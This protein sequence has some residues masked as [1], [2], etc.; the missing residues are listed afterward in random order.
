ME[1]DLEIRPRALALTGSGSGARHFLCGAVRAA[2]RPELWG[3]PASDFRED[4]ARS[5]EPRGP[6][7]VTSPSPALIGPPPPGP[8]IAGF[9]VRLEFAK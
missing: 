2:D 1:A 3:G 5:A 7:R 4:S 9:S 6:Q 8:M